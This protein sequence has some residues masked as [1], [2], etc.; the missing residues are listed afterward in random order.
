[1]SSGGSAWR[2]SNERRTSCPATGALRGSEFPLGATV[3]DTG[4][5]F[6]VPSETADGM[7][8]C[9]SDETGAE[10]RIPHARLRRRRLT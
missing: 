7:V 4:T 9:L 2:Q 6:A 8:L 5:D 3:T 10:T 1:M